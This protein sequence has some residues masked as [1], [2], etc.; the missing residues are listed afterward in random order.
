M[1]KIIFT[2]SITF[3]LFL[4]KATFLETNLSFKL[5][6]SSIWFEAIIILLTFGLIFILFKQK[7]YKKPIIFIFHISIISILIGGGVTRYFGYEG[8]LHLREGEKKDF[9]TIYN[10]NSN[11]SYSKNLG[12]FVKL[13]KFKIEKYMGS[14]SP[15]TYESF[16][17]VID[18][19]NSFKHHIYMNN[20]LKY[21][22]FRF[23]QM[24]YDKDEK[25]SVL[26]VSKDYG[27]YITYFGYFLLTLGFIALFF[28]QK[29]YFKKVLNRNFLILF[30]LL[31]TTDLKALSLDEYKQNSPLLASKFS[32]ILIQHNGRIKPIDS[33]ALDVI[34]KLS[35]KR[36]I[37]N[38]NYNELFL[39]IF[40]YPELFSD[41]KMIKIKNAKIKEILKLKTNFASY[42]NFF[43]NNNFLLKN[44]IQNALKKSDKDRSKF[45]REVL[46]L[47]EK[48]Y[49]IYEIMEAKIFTLFPQK[50]SSTWLDITNLGFLNDKNL[51]K[52]YHFTFLEL[53]K[54]LKEFKLKEVEKN[55]LTLESIQKENFPT[56]ST[57][58]KDFEILYNRLNIFENLIYVYLILA[59]FILIFAFIEILK[60][61][62][63]LKLQKIVSFIT[64]SLLIIQSFNMILRW[65]ISG[66][67]PW[68]N[69]Y[70]SII[71]I[72]WSVVLATLI[73]RKHLL[74]VASGFLVAGIFMFS[75]HLNDIDPQITNMVPV[76]KSYWLL[77]H[78]SVITSS[79]GFLALASIIGLFNMILFSIKKE[80]KIFSDIIYLSI[81]IGLFLLTIGTILGAI[82]ANESWGRYWSWDPKETWSLISIIVYTLLLHSRF[83]TK[84]NDFLF[85]T[86]SFL[87]FFVII[88]TYF[89]VNFYIANGL[90]SYGHG[91]LENLGWLYGFIVMF[92]GFINIEFEKILIGFKLTYIFWIL[93]AIL[94][95]IG[96]KRSK[97]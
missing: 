42:D 50:E 22:G 91:A 64:L 70:E 16:V 75:A 12:F 63:F 25:G 43:K 95:F 30:L 9:I 53:Y 1:K 61:T 52:K 92:D 68:S 57:E 76:L 96:L 83:M 90:H 19:K 6:Y 85:S 80:K 38:L 44:E 32:Q 93:F 29:T 81:F 56:I 14:N 62:E 28:A 66:H 60:E 23:Y 20:I 40:L 10:K 82:W 3:I 11:S 21:N 41:F 5:I 26:L 13:N 15:S 8:V 58:K 86:F 89:G 65:Y 31:F 45:D 35:S 48:L 47:N 88:M 34:H 71:L 27:M 49:L 39:G 77:L 55:I 46:K 67:A 17:E 69:S 36:E 72:A 33:L 4:M 18:N 59:I 51:A 78:V 54:N 87:S 74:I 73:F 79:Y 7:T 94:F 37:Q 97:I 24:S 2:L 84:Q